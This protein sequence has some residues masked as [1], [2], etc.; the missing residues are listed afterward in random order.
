MSN[1]IFFCFRA[2]T[3]I[4]LGKNCGLQTLMVGTGVHKLEQI[5]EW[6]RSDKAEEKRLAADY[7]LDAL[8]DLKD[9]L[10]K[11]NVN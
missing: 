3:D 7:Y 8:G 10:K 4:L 5:R 6:E 1:R 9:L 11:A 2:N